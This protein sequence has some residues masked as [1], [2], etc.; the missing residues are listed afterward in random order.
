M[1]LFRREE[2]LSRMLVTTVGKKAERDKTAI[3]LALENECEGCGG[4]ERN[5]V[6]L[7]SFR[8]SAS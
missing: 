7:C 3:K 5:G 6:T 1:E 2:A 8:V 4:S